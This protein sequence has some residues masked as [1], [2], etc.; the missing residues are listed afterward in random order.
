MKF[1]KFLT[2]VELDEAAHTSGYAKAAYGKR[3][4]AA[5]KGMTFEERIKVD[6]QRNNVGAYRYSRIAN[7]GVAR[8]RRLST[9][10]EIEKIEATNY[11]DG[12]KSRQE[13]NVKNPA[14]NQTTPAI[15]KHTFTEPPARKRPF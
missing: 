9:P 8:N 13:N 15:Q 4:G 2:Q 3:M 1:S 11:L 5:A 12:I 10:Q 14:A 7:T 6:M